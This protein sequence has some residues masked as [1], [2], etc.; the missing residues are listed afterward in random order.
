MGLSL[1]SE[2][3]PVVLKKVVNTLNIAYICSSTKSYFVE[4]QMRH[5]NG[6]LFKKLVRYMKYRTH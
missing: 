1:I 2:P 3:C 6:S 5:T 4:S